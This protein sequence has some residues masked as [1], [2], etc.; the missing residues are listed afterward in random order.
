M[1]RLSPVSDVIQATGRKVAVCEL[2]CPVGLLPV[3]I[4]LRPQIN[5]LKLIVMSG[6]KLKE[7]IEIEKKL[8]KKE[9]SIRYKFSDELAVQLRRCIADLNRLAKIDRIIEKDQLLYSVKTN[10]KAGY[11]DVVRNY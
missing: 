3:R 6:K 9:D 8:R 1:F 11:V 10:R 4:R 5:N 7:R 2:T